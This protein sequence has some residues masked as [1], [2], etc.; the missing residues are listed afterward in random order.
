M[1]TKRY[2]AAIFSVAI[3]SISFL[4]CDPKEDDPTPN[5]PTSTDIFNEVYGFYGKPAAQV[6]PILDAKGWIKDSLINEFAVVYYYYTPDSLKMYA[7]YSINNIIKGSG[8]GEM[9]SSSGFHSKLASNTNKFLSYFE[10]WEQRLSIV[11]ISNA[12]YQGSIY[13]D[14]FVFMQD[15]NDR[16]VFLADLQAKKTTL[17]TASSHFNGEEMKGEVEVFLDYEDNDS[18]VYVVFEDSS[19]MEEKSRTTQN[20]W[21]RRLKH[22]NN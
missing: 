22:Y 9:E 15:Y 10:N 18:E 12:T 13:A 17:N 5:P 7:V 16:A 6:L 2:L 21:F 8:Y 3:L 14:D 1:N 11:D 4:A 20:H 19:I